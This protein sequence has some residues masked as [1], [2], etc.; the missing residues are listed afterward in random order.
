M[1]TTSITSR[2]ARPTT[3]IREVRPSI[4]ALVVGIVADAATTVYGISI[5][6]LVYEA[7][8]LASL[9]IPWLW[10]TGE[11]GLN[12]GE[13]AGLYAYGYVAVG[14]A[15]AGVLHYLDTDSEFQRHPISSGFFR[16]FTRGVAAVFVASPVLNMV[17]LAKW[18]AWVP[19]AGW[20]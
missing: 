19:E 10:R 4:L 17:Q 5:M 8:P 20:S 15:V 3:R 18:I 14:I 12:L 9:I 6:G 1:S 13:A 7:G 2:I 16:R 11:F